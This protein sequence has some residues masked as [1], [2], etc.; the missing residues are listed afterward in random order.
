MRSTIRLLLFWAFCGGCSIYSGELINDREITIDSTRDVEVKR[1]AL[2]DFIWG[3]SGFPQKL[4]PTVK[5]NVAAPVKGLT[6]LA[7][8]DEF[9]LELAKDMEGLA[10]H[11]VPEHSNGE[12]VVVHH[13]HACTLDDEP[14]PKDV[15]YGL[16]R[17]IDSL[18]GEGYG[19]L[20]VFMPRMRPGDCGG[21]H[22]SLFKIQTEGSPMK[23]FLETTAASLNYL[24]QS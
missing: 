24:N 3:K 15:G 20:G 12:L 16:Q 1:R 10:Y 7:R 9:R 6:N 22:D 2:I 17:T 21:S 13:G 18:L 8:V 14:G 19:V 11:F 5:Q 23:F 4:L